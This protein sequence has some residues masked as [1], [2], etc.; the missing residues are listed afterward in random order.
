MCNSRKTRQYD[1]RCYYSED[2]AEADQA[3]SEAPTH[4]PTLVG[5]VLH[6]VEYLR[7][8]DILATRAFDPQ[9][10]SNRFCKRRKTQ[11]SYKIIAT[12]LRAA[13]ECPAGTK[14]IIAWG[15]GLNKPTF[16][17][18]ASAPN[19]KLRKGLSKYFPIVM[20]SEYLTSQR[21]AKCGS[22]VKHD[23]HHETTT[24][25]PNGPPTIRS[26]KIRGLFRCLNETCGIIWSRDIC[27]ALSI[28]K[29]FHHQITKRNLTRP[30]VYTKQ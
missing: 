10:R 29:I 22:A 15:A 9:V 18:H 21:C 30:D 5:A 23:K 11:R 17:G 6:A 16:R 4:T 19:K 14:M 7:H 24:Q 25:Q 8:W 28:L 3:L 27:S 12:K 20:V 26:F 2:V 1:D 13:M